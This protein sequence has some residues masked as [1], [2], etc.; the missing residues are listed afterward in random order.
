LRVSRERKV[1]TVLF[2]DLVGFTSRAETLDPEDV[3]AILRPYHERLRYE[4]ERWGGT[5]E[6][7]IGDAVM[8]LFGAPVTREDDPERAVRAALSIRD[9][10]LEQGELQVRIAVNTGEAL[11][12]LDARPEAGEGMAT[13]DVVN[14]ASRLQSAAPVNGILVGEATYRATAET[15][16]YRDHAEVEAKGKEAPVPV[17]GVVQARARFGVDL[18]PEARTPLVGRE[19]ELEQLVGALERARQQRSTE[20]VTLIGVPGIGKSRLV[21]ELFQSIERGGVLTY[22]RQGRSLPYGAGVSYWALAEM[23]KAQAGILETDTDEDVEAKLARTVEQ[24][25]DEDAEWVLSHLRPLVGQAGD[26]AG[27]QDEA[28]VAWRRF[29]EALA[30][31]HA[32]VLMFEDIHWADDGLLDFIEHLADWVRD[33]P[34]LILCT[35]RLDLLER[36]PGWGGGKLN[37]ANVALAPL[38]DEETAKLI[39]ALSERPLLEAELQSALLDRAGGNPLYAEQYVRM[40]AERGAGEELALPETV[41]GIIAARLDALAPAEKA[42]LH[43]AAV[44]GKVF[45]LGALGAT[46]QQLHPLQQKEFVQ[47][48]RRSSV[49]SETEYAFKHL[50]VRDVAYGQV[51]RAKR[52]QKHLRTAEWIE[53]LG[54]A[55]DHAEMVAHHYVNALELTR[56]AGQDVS[57]IVGRAREALREAGDRALSL[58]A[59]PQAENYFREALALADASDADHPDLLFRLGRALY[60]R[61]EEGEEELAE[62]RD[63]LLAR[64]DSEAAAEA[65]LMLAN[66]VW[67]QGRSDDTVAHLEQARA[68]VADAPPSRIRVSVLSEVARYQMLADE[69]EAAIETGTEALRLAAELGFDDLRAHALNNV[70]SAR[71]ALG[72]RTGFAEIEESIEVAARANAIP[73]L[74][75]GHNNLSTM[76]LVFGELEQAQAGAEETRRLGEHFGQYGYVRF[77]EGGAGVGIPYHMGRW[78][79]AHENAE[80]FLESV[81]QGSPHYQTPAAY[82]FRGLIRL[83]RADPEAAV[84]DAERALEVVESFRDPQIV[85]PTLGMAA[86]IFLGVGDEQRAADVAADAIERLRELA[87]LAFAGVELHY[88]M[89]VASRLGRGA[90]VSEFAERDPVDSAWLRAVRS[91]AASDLPGAA[92]IYDEMGALSAAAFYHLRAAEQLVAEGRRAEADEQLRPALAFYRGARATRYVREGESLLAAS[93]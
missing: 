15:I 87:Q 2:A 72:D 90:E 91:I 50:L 36:R 92:E 49:E 57:A 77:I 78:D 86:H 23:V 45:W 33:V 66:V 58:N 38:S 1:I 84:A 71:A 79:D 30:E 81:E 19:R 93:A 64:G 3:E 85:Q 7:F 25:I 59:L 24:L 88:L 5:V 76:R 16:E 74:L 44:I 20:L 17:W 83:G 40:L 47:R 68:L 11:V 18:T 29:F 14:T 89:W 34:I 4:L 80:R 12:N 31:Q 82:C 54:R 27:S 63:K 61:N 42:L 73:D 43:D 69:N 6:K 39:S 55:E 65:A 62:A 48:A 70:G 8:A 56:A 28:F 21:G 26:A 51:P 41:Q 53:S 60:L 37:S 10:I 9:W 13:G 22:W 75:R 32:L 35:A 67:K 52:A 46:E